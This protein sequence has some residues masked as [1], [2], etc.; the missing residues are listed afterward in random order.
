[1]T[2]NTEQKEQFEGVRAEYFFAD[3][4]EEHFLE[5]KDSDGVKWRLRFSG[6]ENAPE[7]LNGIAR[8]FNAFPTL[9]S[10]MNELADKIVELEK[11][12]NNSLDKLGDSNGKLLLACS[13]LSDKDAEIT[14]LKEENER[15]KA[16]ND[17]LKETVMEWEN[18]DKYMESQLSQAKEREKV[19]EELNGDLHAEIK[20]L[21][22]ERDRI[23]AVFKSFRVESREKLKQA[24]AA[25]KEGECKICNGHGSI[26]DDY[27]APLICEC[28][29]AGEPQQ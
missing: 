17:R 21:R 4:V 2:D 10:E 23:K 3:G 1:M 26:T 14:R 29:V 27:G 16:S 19:Q 9:K 11:S 18:R 8:I 22:E 24:Q 5:L 7:V 12:S 28:T 20:R 6:G 25:L 13:N 15:L